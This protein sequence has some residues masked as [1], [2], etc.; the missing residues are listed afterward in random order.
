MLDENVSELL[1]LVELVDVGVVSSSSNGAS[2]NGKSITA[3]YDVDILSVHAVAWCIVHISGLEKLLAVLN[4][5]M[6]AS[7]SAWGRNSK[8]VIGKWVKRQGIHGCCGHW[9]G[10][11]SHEV[12][13]EIRKCRVAVWKERDRRRMGVA[14]VY[15]RRNASNYFL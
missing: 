9:I 4:W 7:K 13:L 15:E 3:E 2:W 5:A 11:H 14:H 10:W 8:V 1:L 6:V 12:L